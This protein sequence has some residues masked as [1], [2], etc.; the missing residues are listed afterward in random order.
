MGHHHCPWWRAICALRPA[1]CTLYTVPWIMHPRSSPFTRHP[2]T[3][4]P[5]T[6]QPFTLTL[7]GTN[8]A[9]VPKECE[10]ELTYSSLTHLLT[11]AQVPKECEAELTEQ[12]ASFNC[13]PVYL[14]Q[15]D[16]AV[17]KEDYTGFASAVLWPLLHNQV[18]ARHPAHTHAGARALRPAHS[19]PTSSRTLRPA[20][21]VAHPAPCTLHPAPPTLH[22]APCTPRSPIAT[23]AGAAATAPS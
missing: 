1:P 7:T 16:A 10:A 5:F 8:Q 21:C 20:P 4:Q 23:R 9:Q 15:G 2:S 18:H 19:D 22:P 6:L 11:Q 14:P 3:L 17:P 13:V 12:M